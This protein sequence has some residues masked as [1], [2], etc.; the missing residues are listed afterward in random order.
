[1]K[2][3]SKVYLELQ[4]IYKSKAKQDIDEVVETVRTVPGGSGI[5]RDDVELFCKNARFVKLL[6]GP[7]D[8]TSMRQIIRK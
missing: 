5:A 2:A 8:G 3:L 4:Y 7:H 1:M 6:R